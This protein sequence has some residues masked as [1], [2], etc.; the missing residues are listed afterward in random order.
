MPLN[1]LTL[2]SRQVR[3]CEPLK[4]LPLTTLGLGYCSHI[5]DF[6]PLKGLPLTVLQLN[7]CKVRDLEPFK[8]MK[9]TRLHLV[10][11]P[12]SDLELL[13]GMPLKHLAIFQKPGVTDLRPLQGMEL[14]E[15]YLTPKNITQGLEILRD[16]KS[17]KTIGIAYTQAWPAAEFWERYDKG[18]FKE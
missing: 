6:T 8:G 11:T 12:V 4:G 1:R 10:G 3:D 2:F 9:L 16:M 13:K 14:D 5:E 18:E 15:I 7:D 17:L